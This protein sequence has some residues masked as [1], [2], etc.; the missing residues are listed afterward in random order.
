[1]L[2]LWL[3]HIRVS[4]RTRWQQ[5]LLGFHGDIEK[6]DVGSTTD[7]IKVED[8]T[9]HP[10]IPDGRRYRSQDENSVVWQA[11]LQYTFSLQKKCTGN[12][13]KTANW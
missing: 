1:M 11:E 7:G 8:T 12:M 3:S 9:V 13:L 2:R 10:E 6:S 5:W 4:D